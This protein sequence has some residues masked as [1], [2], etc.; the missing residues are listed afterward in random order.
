MNEALLVVNGVERAVDEVKDAN[1]VVDEA[2]FL[3]YDV[4]VSTCVVTVGVER[5]GQSSS[6]GS[7]TGQGS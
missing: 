5:Q 2:E 7:G 4:V 6:T 1:L 3:A